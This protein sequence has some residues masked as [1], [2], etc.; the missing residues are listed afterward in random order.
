[1]NTRDAHT[2]VAIAAL[3]AAA[4]GN[5]SD[6]ERANIA[7]AAARLGLPADDPILQQAVHGTADLTDLAVN[8]ST[9]EARVA[10]YDTAAAVCNADGEPNEKEAAFLASLS[11]ALGAVAG[12]P[13]ASATYSATADAMKAGSNAGAPGGDVG[14]FILDQAMLA[15]ACELLPHRLAGMAILPLQLRMVYQLG[16]RHG[17]QLDLAQA[18]D[19][20]AVFGIGAAGHMM[21]GI[22]RGVLGS[23]GR[24]V[25]G[26]LIGGATGM[27]A[28]TAVTFATT[29]ALGHAAE[30]YYAQGRKLS[31]ADLKALFSKF[32]GEASTVFPRVEDR[33][34]QLAGSNNLGSV[35]AGLR[36]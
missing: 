3:A 24:G 9:D 35:L 23:I 31:T 6:A 32:Q 17:Q 25:F 10:A 20:I 7:E 33:I 26:S 4:D 1:M 12:S 34:R 27:A 22:V 13:D 21:E 8:L 2:I 5:Q 16:Q 28:G 30:Q 36:T 19:L 11:R 14:T 29:Y 18:K 15:G